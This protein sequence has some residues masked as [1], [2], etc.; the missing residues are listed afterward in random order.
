MNLYQQ[1]SA[2]IIT[3]AGLSLVACE[4]HS[5]GTLLGQESAPIVGDTL[6][7]VMPYPNILYAVGLRSGGSLKWKFEPSP[8]PRRKVSHV[9]S[10]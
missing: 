4:H 1:I 8:R 6:Y 3:A 9:V 5:G 7:F 10:Q 2:L